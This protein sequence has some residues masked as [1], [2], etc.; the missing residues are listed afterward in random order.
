MFTVPPAVWLVV[1]APASV[2]LMLQVLPVPTE[3]AVKVPPMVEDACAPTV[4]P[5]EELRSVTAP[6]D[7]ALSV[8]AAARAADELGAE[9]VRV[10]LMAVVAPV[11]ILIVAGLVMVSVWSALCCRS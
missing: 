6:P 11:M 3:P 5:A 1:T 4:E 8:R 7:P 10:A 2:F 9:L